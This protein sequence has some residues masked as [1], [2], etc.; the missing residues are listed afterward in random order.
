MRRAARPRRPD[1]RDRGLPGPGGPGGPLLARPY[2][3]DRGHVRSARACLRL[4][5]LRLLALPEHR[6]GGGGGASCR[7]AAR[8]G[9]GDGIDDKTWGPGLLCR[10]MAHRQKI[11][12][13][14]PLRRCRSGSRGR[15][16]RAGGRRGSRARAHRGR[17]R[18]RVGAPSVALLRSGLAL[19]LD[20][21]GA[22]ARRRFA[23]RQTNSCCRRLATARAARCLRAR[24]RRGQSGSRAPRRRRER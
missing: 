19:C 14:G 9:A 20:C 16:P 22:P 17:L 2:A 10:A 12:R 4:F 23:E 15:A 18:R 1:S 7:A 24:G 13:R 5:H 8:A 3:A 11:E 6:D 21:P